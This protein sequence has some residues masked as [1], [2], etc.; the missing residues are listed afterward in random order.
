MRRGA[1]FGLGKS[2]RRP[3]GERGA[4]L[5]TRRA[6]APCPA[7]PQPV[8]A[9]GGLVATYLRDVSA[10][11]LL[12]REGELELAFEMEEACAEMLRIFAAASVTLP[13]LAGL[14]AQV[15]GGRRASLKGVLRKRPTAREGGGSLLALLEA[16][17]ELLRRQRSLQ[18]R[19][20]AP[21]A[22]AR[23]RDNLLAALEDLAARRAEGLVALGLERRF[24]AG[25]AGGLCRELEAV[26][27]ET[28]AVAPRAGHGS[29]RGGRLAVERR[30]GRPLVALRAA[31][32]ALRRQTARYERAAA[33][34]AR[35][36]LR[37]VVS[38]A[39]HYAGYGV[40]L[41]DLI[42]EGNLG[43]IRAID[44]Y[45]PALGFRFSTYATWWIG[46]SVRRAL[47]D[48][49]RT[50]R[51]PVHLRE[52]LARIRRTEAELARRLGRMPTD[53]E[54]GELM[55][56]RT[57]WIERARVAFRTVI[58]LDAPVGAED[59]RSLVDLLEGEPGP[60]PSA[61]RRLDVHRHAHRLLE[62]LGPREQL[63][64]KQRFGL[65][66][67]RPRTLVEIGGT[68]GLTRERVRQIEAAALGQLRETAL[69]EGLSGI[70][71]E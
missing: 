6:R 21:R 43:L 22:T 24:V 33:E 60:D 68:L 69:A 19:L 52:K 11:G 54:I 13:A 45:E 50:V 46:Q 4:A 53:E 62:A 59:E 35:A 66:G 41:P 56:G 29:R 28:G 44:K 58:S 32:V 51:V 12:C 64:L 48:T 17:R 55:D 26:T 37:L 5:S 7:R 25:L 65:D 57:E 70:L 18:R 40:P 2:P 27:A 10:T 16:D 3:H 34:M 14:Q 63:I 31:A 15:S 30:Y 1:G 8:D 71:D 47:S 38:I 23:A 39:G 61:E 42:Q 9:V 36:N 49:G 20:R 67:A